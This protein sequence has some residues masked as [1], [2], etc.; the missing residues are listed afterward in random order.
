[1]I[2]LT[3]CPQTRYDP[4]GTHNRSKASLRKWYLCF[5]EYWHNRIWNILCKNINLRIKYYWKMQWNLCQSRLV[6]NAP[7]NRKK[8]NPS[9]MIK[10]ISPQ[11]NNKNKISWGKQ[12][13]QG[14]QMRMEITHPSDESS[15]RVGTLSGWEFQKIGYLFENVT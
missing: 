7:L 6:G 9:E 12:D 10:K 13:R 4:R 11:W 8:F 14:R 2:R 1:M 5:Q 3:M 15:R